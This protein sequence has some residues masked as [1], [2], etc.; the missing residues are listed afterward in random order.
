MNDAMF[1]EQ[2]EGVT[3]AKLSGELDLVRAEPVKVALMRAVSNQDYG[4]VIDMREVTYLD[5]AG[6]NVLFEAAERL[7]GRQQRLVAV[8]PETALIQRVLTLV[9]ASSVMDMHPS[10]AEAIAAVRALMPRDES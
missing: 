4:L 7:S 5:S 9:N 1:L 3:V 8:V 2:I 6:V 10:L